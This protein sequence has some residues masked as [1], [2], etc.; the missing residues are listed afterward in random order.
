MEPELNITG[1][2]NDRQELHEVIRERQIC[3]DT[4]P[5]YITDKKGSLIQIGYQINLYGTLPDTA[6]DATPDSSEY[7]EAERDV[8][9]VAEALSKTCSPLHMC[10]ST[11]I[12]EDTITYSQER[13]MRPD[14]T[15]HIPLFDQA[16][17]GHPVNDAI[18]N[19]LHAAAALLETAGV[20]KKKWRE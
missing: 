7:E 6:K 2:F 9:R 14:V 10:E 12:E 16:D 19:T 5:Y 11:T 13:K 15:V 18:T 20:R 4:E 17:F 1:L 8:K 3:Y